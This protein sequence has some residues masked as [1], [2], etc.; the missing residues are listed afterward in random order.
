MNAKG[1]DVCYW[2]G[3]NIYW[4]KARGSGILFVFLRATSG[5]KRVKRLDV[6]VQH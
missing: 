4:K 1:I 6:I 5:L 3:Q 2:Q